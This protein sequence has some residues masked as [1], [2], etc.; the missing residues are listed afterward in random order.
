MYLQ[1]SIANNSRKLVMMGIYPKPKLID[2]S[3]VIYSVDLGRSI[4][5]R[6]SCDRA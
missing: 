2:T 1:F 4:R 3:V 5:L 6:Q